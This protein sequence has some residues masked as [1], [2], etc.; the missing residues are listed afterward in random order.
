MEILFTVDALIAFLTLTFLEIV[1]GI[2]N[3]IFISIVTGKLPPEQWKK[4]TQFGWFLACLW[5]MAFFFAFTCL[6]EIKEPLF[7]MVW[8]WF[9]ADINE[10]ELIYWVEESF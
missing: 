6:T 7:S 4:A 5:R 9:K 2:D 3:V 10:K 8:D 1:L